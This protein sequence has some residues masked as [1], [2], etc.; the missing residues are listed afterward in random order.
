MPEP[1]EACPAS[2]HWHIQTG[3]RNLPAEALT[4]VV[5]WCAEGR[6]DRLTFRLDPGEVRPAGMVIAA[7][8]ERVEM[9][10]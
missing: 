1:I 6:S 4:V 3:R 7:V 5:L 2:P 10:A 9:E 8:P